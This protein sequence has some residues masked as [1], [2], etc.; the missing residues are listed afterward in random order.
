LAFATSIAG[1]A[2]SWL[3]TV[4]ESGAFIREGESVT[5]AAHRRVTDAMANATTGVP[6]FHGDF[7]PEG[8]YHAA[9]MGE[10]AQRFVSNPDRLRLSRELPDWLE[11]LG[12]AGSDHAVIGGS[13]IS[14]KPIPDDIDFAYTIPDGRFNTRQVV[15]ALR[16][17]HHPDSN[18][19]AEPASAVNGLAGAFPFTRQH[20]NYLELYS[21]V[22]GKALTR[23]T[24]ALPTGDDAAFALRQELDKIAAAKGW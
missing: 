9:D 4:D 19:Q 15:R 24:V 17:L 14:R 5:E 18:I 20:E 10:F 12:A 1:R 6:E 2:L 21:H 3:R 16:H 8:V 23:G 11:A 13:F 7:L 22:K